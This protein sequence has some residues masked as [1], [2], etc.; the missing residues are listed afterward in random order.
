MINPHN[1]YEGSRVVKDALA[2]PWVNLEDRNGCITSRADIDPYS[3]TYVLR[4]TSP[5]YPA[6]TH[7]AM[8]VE[9]EL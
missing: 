6:T 3:P 9:L 5:A 4:S 7:S 1:P 8:D 2:A